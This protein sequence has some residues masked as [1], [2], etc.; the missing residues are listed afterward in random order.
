MLGSG[1]FRVL[2]SAVA[3]ESPSSRECSARRGR[4]VTAQ[5]YVQNPSAEVDLATWS[6]AATTDGSTGT[7]E[8]VAGG[9]IGDWAFKLRVD[10]G[11]TGN[12]QCGIVAFADATVCT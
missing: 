1:R 11:G 10:D 12:C 4:L 7:L 5:N 3:S 6:F 8:R 9:V 2:E